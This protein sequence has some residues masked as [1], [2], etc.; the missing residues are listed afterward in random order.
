MKR[1]REESAGLDGWHVFRARLRTR[2]FVGTEIRTV[3]GSYCT[4]INSGSFDKFRI[5][6]RP[7]PTNRILASENSGASRILRPNSR[8]G[9]EK[10]FPK[11]FR[12]MLD[13]AI[14]AMVLI[15]GANPLDFNG[16]ISDNY[17]PVNL[18]VASSM[19]SHH[20]ALREGEVDRLEE[21]LSIIAPSKLPS[22]LVRAA[23]GRT[24]K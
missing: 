7:L 11:H 24:R 23:E 2:R 6:K 12:R 22:H 1:S 18:F 9:V 15:R 16:L 17:L 13:P 8:K 5:L 10:Y 3:E 4:I 20:A 21:R 14:G 19:T